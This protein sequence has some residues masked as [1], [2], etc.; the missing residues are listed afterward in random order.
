VIFPGEEEKIM[1]TQ[2]SKRF[3]I[4]ILIYA[5]CSVLSGLFHMFSPQ[6]VVAQDQ[7]IERV[8]GGAM[9]AF[10]LGAWLAYKERSWEKIRIVVL[11]LVAWTILYT[12][13]L[14]WGVLS[15]GLLVQALGST[16]F[17]AILAFLLTFLYI[18]EE[19]LR[20]N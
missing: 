13:T 1:T 10:A 7:A 12:I 3:R 6:T 8:L 14:A 2:T 20:S 16:I 4:V 11:M 9:L 15:G 5:I 18:C 19:K 17:G